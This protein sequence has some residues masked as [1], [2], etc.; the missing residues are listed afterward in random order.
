MDFFLH[1]VELN[2]LMRIMVLFKKLLRSEN[3][4]MQKLFV[5][6]SN[7]PLHVYAFYI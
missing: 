2:K 6:V 1:L 3:G 7:L 4:V 5:T